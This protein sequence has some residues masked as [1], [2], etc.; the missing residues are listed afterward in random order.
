MRRGAKNAELSEDY[1]W[2]PALAEATSFLVKMLGVLISLALAWIVFS[3][4]VVPAVIESATCPH[5]YWC[6]TSR[7]KSRSKSNWTTIAAC[8]VSPGHT[9]SRFDRRSFATKKRCPT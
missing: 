3:W 4:L 1:P 6:A 8:T 5:D 7:H 2:T 9:N